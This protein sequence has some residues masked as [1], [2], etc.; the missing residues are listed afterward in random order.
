MD[1]K[2]RFLIIRFSSFGDIVQCMGTLVSLKQAY[3]QSEVHWVARRDYASLL[4]MDQRIDKVWPY[5]RETGPKGLILLA[6]RLRDE[7]FDD[8]YDAHNNVRSHIVR[9]AFFLWGGRG[10]GYR[11]VVRR[12]ER[13]KRFFLFY[14]RVNLF[15]RPYRGIKSYL[16]PLKAWGI[17]EKGPEGKWAFPPKTLQKVQDEVFSRLSSQRPSVVIIPSAAWKMKRWP[18]AHWRELIGRLEDYQFIVLAGPQDDFCKKL[19]LLDRERVFNFAGKLSLIESCA[20]LAKSSFFVSADT[21]FLHVGDLLGISGLALMGP[22]AF[23]HPMGPHIQTLDVPLGCRP[24][25]KDG[26]GRC[27]QRT[28]QKCM[29]DIT[30]KRVAA[31]ILKAT[32]KK[33]QPQL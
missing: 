9:W 26:Q 27:V 33:R 15:P 28:Y 5:D 3:P 10:K 25:T 8:V 24:C 13:L 23:G 6:K 30:P 22:T 17:Q 7:G 14:F 4:S 18:V 11:L 16:H 21:G 29:V 2:R 12:K 19:A 20:V 32:P 1:K 31:E